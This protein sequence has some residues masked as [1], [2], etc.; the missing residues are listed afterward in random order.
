[1]RHGG[2]AG[3]LLL[4]HVEQHEI[5]RTRHEIWIVVIGE[6]HLHRVMHLAENIVERLLGFFGG[7]ASAFLVDPRIEQLAE[8]R[9]KLTP[10]NLKDPDFVQRVHHQLMRIADWRSNPQMQRL[11]KD[12]HIEPLFRQI[13][14]NADYRLSKAFVQSLRLFPRKIRFARQAYSYIT[15]PHSVYQHQEADLIRASRYASR[16]DANWLAFCK[17]KVLEKNAYFYSRMQSCNLLGRTVLSLKD[18]ER[19]E[20]CFD[21]EVDEFVLTSLTILLSQFREDNNT[22][23]I[24]KLVLHP[25]ARVEIAS[26]GSY[27]TGSNKRLKNISVPYLAK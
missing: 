4:D 16:L 14:I 6:D 19:V 25:N 11:E 27:L 23:I 9:K 10:S 12:D 21:N 5:I 18:L 13:K 20:K 8:I 7:E 3:E 1:M 15:S 24:Q 17:K 22:R 2:I 26:A